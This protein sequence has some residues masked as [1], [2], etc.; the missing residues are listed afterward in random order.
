MKFEVKLSRRDFLKWS[1]KATGAASLSSLFFPELVK[2]LEAAVSIHPVIW[3]QGAGCTG[4]SVSVINTVYPNIKSVLLEEIVPGHQLSV[5]YHPT[6]MASAGELAM[7][8]LSDTASK[9]K[10]RYVLVVEGAIPIG[11]NGVYCTI[12]EVGQTELTMADAVV[13]LGKDAMAV[14]ALGTCASYGGIP[15]GSPNPTSN[16]GVSEVF[17]GNR[18]TTSV[19]NIP[20]CAT[21]P[22]WFVG[23]V[24]SVLLYGLPKPNAV[25]AYGRLKLFYG[26]K[27]HDN[28]ER[29]S[30]FNEGKFAEGF[31]EEGCLIKLGCKGPLAGADCPV[32]KWNTK[33]SWCIKSGAP[34]MACTEPEFP[35]GVSPLYARLPEAFVQELIAKAK[36]VI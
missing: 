27:V 11:E 36:E 15:A 10:G 18:V 7:S 23:T 33:V 26:K 5:R 17:K 22:D 16:M 8:V 19:I 6:I 35:D 31:G 30:C 14:L 25:D 20:G 21:H 2:A 13:K 12:G 34:C 29:R 24:A 32:R 1:A 28:C 3:L 9:E 4:C